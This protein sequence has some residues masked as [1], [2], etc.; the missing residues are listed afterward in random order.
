MAVTINIEREE[1]LLRCFMEG[2]NDGKNQQEEV[3]RLL[4]TILREVRENCE[5]ALR[6][7]FERKVVEKLWADDLEIAKNGLRVLQAV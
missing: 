7:G 4:A 1:Y 6:G 5:D 2:K 3:N